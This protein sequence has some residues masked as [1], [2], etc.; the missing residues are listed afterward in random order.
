MTDK[1]IEQEA[2]LWIRHNHELLDYSD[3][4]DDVEFDHAQVADLAELYRVGYR[5][6]EQKGPVIKDNADEN[7]APILCRLKDLGVIKSWY[8]NGTYHAQ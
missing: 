2:K 8:Y 6:C 4:H 1:E 5:A 7:I 3:F